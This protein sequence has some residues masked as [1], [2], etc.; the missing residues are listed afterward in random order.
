MRKRKNAESLDEINQLQKKGKK[1][2]VLVPW[3]EP[4]KKK[5]KTKVK[6]EIKTTK[7]TK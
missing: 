1:S 4:K 6:V 3:T 7:A 2:Q 5:R